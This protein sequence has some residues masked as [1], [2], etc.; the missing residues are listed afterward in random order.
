MNEN[1]YLTNQEKA[2]TLSLALAVLTALCALVALFAPSLRT[3]LTFLAALF[4]T[5]LFGYACHYLEANNV[6]GQSIKKYVTAYNFFVLHAIALAFAQLTGE[7]GTLSNNVLWGITDGALLASLI[8]LINV[9][10]PLSSAAVTLTLAVVQFLLTLFGVDLLTNIVFLV[11]GCLLAFLSFKESLVSALLGVVVAILSLLGFFNK[12]TPTMHAYIHYLALVLMALVAYLFFKVVDP[13]R[14]LEGEYNVGS[15]TR[16]T[17]DT[18]STRTTDYD[19]TVTR[20]AV[21]SGAA[22][23]AASTASK[24]KKKDSKDSKKTTVTRSSSSVNYKLDRDWFIVDYRD[25]PWEELLD[26]P[27]YAF[28]GVSEE[29]AEDLKSAFGIKTIRE[30]AESKYFAWAKEIYE[31]AN[32]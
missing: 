25:L 1:T 32:K 30:F 21:A 8:T 6:Q 28:K 5:L 31:E 15:L 11:A 14:R 7:P 4:A 10:K 3:I 23:T 9:F 19:S 17:Y 12:Q 22:A 20:G 29:M 26:A 16:G 13:S 18:G 24:S 2:N 27:V